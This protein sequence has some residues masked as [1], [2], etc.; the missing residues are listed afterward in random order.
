M[1][2]LMSFDKCMYLCIN[3]HNQIST[4]FIIQKFPLMALCSQYPSTEI[5]PL[6]T[7]LSFLEIHINRNII[8]GL[9]CLASFTWHNA[10]EIH[11]Y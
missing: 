7:V 5:L 9:L 3:H 4:S 11:L 6:T 1:C 10:F 8:C 2:K